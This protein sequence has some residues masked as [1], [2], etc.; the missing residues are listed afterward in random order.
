M[1]KAADE[2][3][4]TE[5]L[6]GFTAC[7]VFPIG[8]SINP[9]SPTGN[10]AAPAKFIAWTIDYESDEQATFGGVWRA[11]GEVRLEI[12]I[13]K[14]CAGHIAVSDTLR[15]LFLAA[16]ATATG[17][18]FALKDKLDDL[19]EEEGGMFSFRTLRLSFLRFGAP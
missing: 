9:P 10:P 16:N 13:E 12:G 7:P 11:D 1:G 4:V 15:A 6:E 17:F 3:K 5:I 19:E 18:T 8:P 14:D 2:L